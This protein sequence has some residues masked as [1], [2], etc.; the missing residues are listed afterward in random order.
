[1]N[2]Q[3]ASYTQNLMTIKSL[4]LDLF[5]IYFSGFRLE[6][7]ARP[8]PLAHGGF[9]LVFAPFLELLLDRNIKQ[10]ISSHDLGACLWL[11]LGPLVEVT[12]CGMPL[13]LNL[14]DLLSF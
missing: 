9:G 10:V 12:A 8:Y 11:F 3:F 6:A 5:P 2:L 7:P 1:M 13:I 4:D 14:M